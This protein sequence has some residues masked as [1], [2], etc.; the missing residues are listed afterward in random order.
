MQ[1]T[2]AQ[3]HWTSTRRSRGGTAARRLKAALLTR[4][5][6]SLGA[7]ALANVTKQR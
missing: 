7:F 4:R 5:A 6:N 1:L 3:T 2:L